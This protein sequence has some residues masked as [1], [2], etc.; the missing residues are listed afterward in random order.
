VVPAVSVRVSSSGDVG[1]KE[2]PKIAAFLA[3]FFLVAAT[4]IVISYKVVV[5]IVTRLTNK[6]RSRLYSIAKEQKGGVVVVYIG[7]NLYIFVDLVYSV[8]D[9]LTRKID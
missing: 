3:G 2:G 8:T 1:S 4:G 9:Y 7:S 6:R 5:I